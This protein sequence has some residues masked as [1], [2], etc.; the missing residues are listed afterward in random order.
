MHLFPISMKTSGT[1][2]PTRRAKSYAA[3]S[4]HSSH[5]D[6]GMPSSRTW[7]QPSCIK[8]FS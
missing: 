6:Q 7:E 5:W 3:Y 2:Q 8:I 1:D 4:R